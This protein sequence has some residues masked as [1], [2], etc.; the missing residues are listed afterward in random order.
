MN[1]II[2]FFNADNLIV[3]ILTPVNTVIASSDLDPSVG[4][5]SRHLFQIPLTLNFGK[6]STFNKKIR[7]LA[8]KIY[9]IRMDSILRP[10][11]HN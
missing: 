1:H 8:T 4:Y 7:F 5:D 2:D 6:N 3:I 10:L 11:I 9:I